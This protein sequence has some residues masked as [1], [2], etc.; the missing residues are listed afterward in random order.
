MQPFLATKRRAGGPCGWHTCVTREGNLHSFVH[1]GAE[2]V[3]PVQRALRDAMWECCGVV[4]SGDGLKNGPARV[5][6][7]NEAP[8]PTNV[9]PTA[10]G[11]GD[12]AHV[13]DL[14]ASLITA[15]ASLLGAIERRESRGCHNPLDYP[16]LRHARSTRWVTRDP[17]V[18]RLR[19][20]KKTR[21][22][23]SVSMLSCS[24]L[25]RPTAAPPLERGPLG[26]TT[27][28]SDLHS[29]WVTTTGAE[30]VLPP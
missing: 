4:R 19:I 9:R 21:C 6:E 27:S 7:L 20:A 14:R 28:L 26:T 24:H 16:K 8:G 13:L 10:E 11:Y 22:S 5:A 18:Y 2:L 25:R 1:E 3:R 15:K 17:R 30:S 23:R 29:S 12:L